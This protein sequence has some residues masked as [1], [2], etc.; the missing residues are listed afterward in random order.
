VESPSDEG[1]KNLLLRLLEE[2]IA[3]GKD[4]ILKHCSTVRAITLAIQLRPS[5]GFRE[6]EDIYKLY[7]WEFNKSVAPNILN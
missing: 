5:I 3:I 2:Y 7:K 6:L 1:A 4:Y